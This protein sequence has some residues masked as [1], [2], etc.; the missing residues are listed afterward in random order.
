[1]TDEP[2]PPP[3]GPASPLCAD[4]LFQPSASTAVKSR[5]EAA[6]TFAQLAEGGTHM[7]SLDFPE[8]IFLVFR[9]EVSIDMILEHCAAARGK[10]AFTEGEAF[11]CGS[12]VAEKVMRPAEPDD[13]QQLLNMMLCCS[14]DPA[15]PQ[16]GFIPEFP[17]FLPAREA[18]D[19]REPG[20]A[21]GLHSAL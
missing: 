17:E 9:I 19:E 12:A 16:P 20:D 15:K 13:R 10:D 1:M 14:G 5:E 11:E 4:G 18:P 21:P 2:P 7:E 6:A 3:C 8:Y